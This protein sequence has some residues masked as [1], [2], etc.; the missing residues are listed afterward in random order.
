MLAGSWTGAW[1]RS[2]GLTE[3]PDIKAI[4]VRVVLLERC[5][6]RVANM[7]SSYEHTASNP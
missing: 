7:M 3:D 6:E 5:L 1:A 4:S 2:G